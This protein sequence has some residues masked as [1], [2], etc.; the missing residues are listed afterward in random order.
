MFEAAEIAKF[1]KRE[2]CE[3]E[4]S[5]KNFRDMYSVITTAEMK[6]EARGRAEEELA[7]RQKNAQKMKQKGYP[8]TDIS[9]ITGLSLKEIEEL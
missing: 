6:G 5:L 8:L 9:E 7:E 2:L 1:S 4:D 3:Y